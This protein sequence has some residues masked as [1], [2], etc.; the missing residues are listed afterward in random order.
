M[1]ALGSLEEIAE[2]TKFGVNI[3]AR[4]NHVRGPGRRLGG[5]GLSPNIAHAAPAREKPLPPSAPSPPE[6]IPEAHRPEVILTGVEVTCYSELIGGIKARLGELGIRQVDFDKLAGFAEGLTGKVFGPS[7]VKRLGPE[8]LFDAIRAAG[9]KLRLEADSEQLEKMQKQIAENCTP[10]QALQARPNNQANIDQRTVDRV[11]IYLTTKKGGLAR[12]RAAVKEAQ[13]N[14]ARHA[15]KARHA[16]SR[17]QFISF[18][19]AVR[20]LPPPEDRP[21]LDTCAAD[22]EATAA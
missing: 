10:R 14:W 9:L 1:D 15:V 22:E 21:A 18:I 6:A 20:I 5:W 19:G 13:S 2:Q 12:L 17:Q 11:L 3:D 16:K 4:T 7:Q 8:K